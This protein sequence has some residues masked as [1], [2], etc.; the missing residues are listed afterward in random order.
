MFWI[1]LNAIQNDQPY[2]DVKEDDLPPRI[3]HLVYQSQMLLVWDQIYHGHLT[4]YWAQVI[5]LLHVD[6]PASG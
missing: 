6:P 4:S 3:L 2:H 5:N 1:G